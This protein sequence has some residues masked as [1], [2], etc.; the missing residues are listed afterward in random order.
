M[1]WPEV[2]LY[3]W[4]VRRVVEGAYRA[5]SPRSLGTSHLRGEL[6]NVCTCRYM[7]IKEEEKVMFPVMEEGQPP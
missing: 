6:V 3:E 5:T 4:F 7:A 1:A 2:M